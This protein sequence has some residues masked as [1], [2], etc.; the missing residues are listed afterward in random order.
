[1]LRSHFGMITW[2]IFYTSLYLLLPHF[3]RLFLGHILLALLPF[4]E[5]CKDSKKNI[6]SFYFPIA[7]MRGDAGS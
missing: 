2:G 3:E 7:H 5:I 1:M 4:E 6:Q